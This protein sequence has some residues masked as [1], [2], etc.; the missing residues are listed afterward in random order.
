M[1]AAGL[2]RRDR[3]LVADEPPTAT[4]QD[5]QATGETCTLLLAAAGGRAADAGAVRFDVAANYDAA[6][7]SELTIA[8]VVRTELLKR[9]SMEQCPRNRR[10]TISIA[11]R[12]QS[13][14]AS[15]ILISKCGGWHCKFTHEQYTAVDSGLKKEIPV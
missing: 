1:A 12:A 4:D 10:G 13:G 15:P 11:R 2:T 9:R 14:T 3:W 7:S 6:A 8:Q 5:R